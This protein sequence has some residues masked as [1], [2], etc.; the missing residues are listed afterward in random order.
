MKFLNNA[1]KHGLLGLCI[2]IGATVCSSTS[3]MSQGDAEGG[4]ISSPGLDCARAAQPFPGA[5]FLKHTPA[6]RLSR[7]PWTPRC[8]G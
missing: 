8:A 5:V 6:R 3:G 1:G 7:Q 4:A 2:V